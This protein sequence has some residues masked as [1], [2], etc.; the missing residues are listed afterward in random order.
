MPVDQSPESLLELVL[1]ASSDE[2]EKVLA[3]W[4]AAEAK[5][6][7]TG[8]IAGVFIGGFLVYLREA[9]SIHGTVDKCLLFL[10][11]GSLMVSV[12]CALVSLL[13][14]PVPPPPRGADAHSMVSDLLRLEDNERKLR[15]SGLFEERIKI[16]ID[17]TDGTLK[18]LKVKL[19]WL[20]IAQKSLLAA[21]FGAAM[22][23]GHRILT[24]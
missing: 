24:Q 19:C 20:T 9:D 17:T 21:V 8:T 13:T 6:Q 16:L 7:G 4:S 18:Q 15:L 5:A 3:K 23:L 12:F 22:D 1:Q 10:A 11:I 2:Y 14:R